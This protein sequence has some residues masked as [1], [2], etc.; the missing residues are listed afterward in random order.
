M[1]TWHARVGCIAALALAGCAGQ[2]QFSDGGM[3]GPFQPPP[4]PMP[5]PPP[6]AFAPAPPPAQT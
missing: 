2:G 3:G 4:P 5:A 1:S 6:A